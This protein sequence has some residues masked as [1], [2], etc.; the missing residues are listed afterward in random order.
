MVSSR[1]GIA[2][3]LRCVASDVSADLD[4][5]G[6]LLDGNR[7]ISGDGTRGGV[8]NAEPP[9]GSL[10]DTLGSTTGGPAG[11]QGEMELE[12]GMKSPVSVVQEYD[13]KK[14]LAGDLGNGF[15]RFNLSPAKVCLLFGVT[16]FWGG[17]LGVSFCFFCC[18][19]F[20][21]FLLLFAFWGDLFFL[22]VGGLVFFFAAFFFDSIAHVRTYVHT[23]VQLP[24]RFSGHARVHLR[25]TRKKTLMTNIPR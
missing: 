13:R 8:D 3:V 12:V 18:L 2:S 6:E 20:F 22:E 16:F 14:K 17:K 15:V 7:H 5:Q 24:C 9:N 21:L 25:V 4:E 11:E 1:C 19:F 23:A 10:G